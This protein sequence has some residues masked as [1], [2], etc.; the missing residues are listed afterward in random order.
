MS[1]SPE[2]GSSTGEWDEV[3][4]TVNASGMSP[5]DY[6]GTISVSSDNADNSPQNMTIYLTIVDSP[7]TVSIIS[8]K[9]GDV[10][11]MIII[12]RATASDDNGVKKVEF[13][14]G[15]ELTATD[16]SSPYEWSWDTTAYSSGTQTIKVRIL[17]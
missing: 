13:Y 16:T 1:V 4:V 5:G 7:P 17:S 9:S 12:I 11:S 15:N 14:I 3:T 10:I 6:S 8:P 2:S